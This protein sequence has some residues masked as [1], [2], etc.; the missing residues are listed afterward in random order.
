MYGLDRACVFVDVQTDILYVRE[1]I[2][3]ARGRRVT[4]YLKK[5]ELEITCSHCNKEIKVKF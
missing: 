5:R 1:R 3:V 4:V 2:R